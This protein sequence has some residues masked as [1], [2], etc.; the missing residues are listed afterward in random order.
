MVSEA[1]SDGMGVTVREHL[2][3]MPTDERIRHIVRILRQTVADALGVTPELVPIDAPLG[4]V[5]AVWEDEW[6]LMVLVQNACRTALGT[7]LR[8][9]EF[10]QWLG[11]RDPLETIQRLAAYLSTNLVCLPPKAGYSDVHDGGIWAW[12]PPALPNDALTK[13][14]KIA[15]VLAGLRSGSTLFRT[16][17]A[18]HPEI[19]CGAELY[20]LPYETMGRREQLLDRLGYPWV[21]W[22]L[23]STI[24][25]FAGLPYEEALGRTQQ[26]V[27]KDSPIS[28]VYAM[29]QTFVGERLLIDKTPVYPADPVW[30]A[31]AESL[32][33]APVYLLLARHPYAAIESFV[34]MRFDELIGNH[35]G[36]WDA[37]PWLYAEKLWAACTITRSLSCPASHPNASCGFAMRTW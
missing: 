26:L 34:R 11:H 1:L 20:L 31:R 28:D 14:R 12:D 2:L 9:W 37:N 30:L 4:D 29:L 17:P 8:G 13:G 6:A 36:I 22:G 7:E 33:E 24:A 35:Y 21:K 18:R 16:M 32:F 19:A 5:D 15:L 23:T 27:D 3:A 25:D 10:H